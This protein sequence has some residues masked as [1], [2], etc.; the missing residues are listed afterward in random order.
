MNESW[1]WIQKLSGLNQVRHK[2]CQYCNRCGLSICNFSN[3]S[4]CQCMAVLG[5]F[6]STNKL[7]VT[8]ICFKS[9]F[10]DISIIIS[11]YHLHS[12]L[13]LSQVPGSVRQKCW[14]WVVWGHGM[15]H[16]GQVGCV[17]TRCGPVGGAV[18]GVARVWWE[19]GRWGWG[20]WIIVVGGGHCAAVTLSVVTVF[21]E[22][23]YLEMVSKLWFTRSL[24][25]RALFWIIKNP[26]PTTQK[27]W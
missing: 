20:Q 10:P 25:L 19:G 9:T 4:I 11:S 12:S 3:Q 13:S 7:Q 8:P 23:K 24:L 17:V 1:I 22:T 18:R 15:R 26:V 5:R 2:V 21:S 6:H 27:L 16:T 14:M